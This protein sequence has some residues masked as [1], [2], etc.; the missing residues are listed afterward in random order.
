M[1]SL[2][3]SLDSL[4]NLQ[5]AIRGRSAKAF[6]ATSGKEVTWND[7]FTAE[8]AM[9]DPDTESDHDDDDEDDLSHSVEDVCATMCDTMRDLFGV[10]S[11]MESYLNQCGA[12]ASA[13]L[14]IVSYG[15]EPPAPASPVVSKRASG[16]PA[17]D[18]ELEGAMELSPSK[19]HRGKQAAQLVLRR[20]SKLC[21]MSSCIYSRARPGEPARAEDSLYCVFCDPVRMAAAMESEAGRMNVRVTLSMLKTKDESV[22]RSAKGKVPLDFCASI[23]YC[24]GDSC[25]YNR[26]HP[27]APV[28]MQEAAA[29]GET[30]CIWCSP[31]RMQEAMQ[32]EAGRRNVQISLSIFEQ[33]DTNVFERATAKVPADFVRSVRTCCGSN[34][35]FSLSSPGGTARAR[36]R[37]TL[38]SWCNPRIVRQREA[39]LH[40]LKR[41]TCA[42]R[43]FADYP[44][45][46]AAA[47]S[48]LSEHFKTAPQRAEALLMERA[49]MLQEDVVRICAGN[50]VA[51]PNTQPLSG[52]CTVCENPIPPM[53]THIKKFEC[54]VAYHAA[55][56][57]E[58][59]VPIET[60][61]DWLRLCSSGAYFPTGIPCMPFVQLHWY[62]NACC[63]TCFQTRCNTLCCRHCLGM[64]RPMNCADIAYV[65]DTYCSGA[66]PLCRRREVISP[67]TPWEEGRAMEANDPGPKNPWWDF[68]FYFQPFSTPED[69]FVRRGR[70]D[71]Y[72]GRK[73]NIHR[74]R[75]TRSMF[76]EDVR[77]I[78]L[79]WLSRHGDEIAADP[80][81]AAAL[82][83]GDYPGMPK[84]HPCFGDRAMN[85]IEVH[86]LREERARIS[87]SAGFMG[88]AR[89]AELPVGLANAADYLSSRELSVQRP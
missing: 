38:C 63:R 47:V 5:A 58:R 67:M 55:R 80:D 39:S 28:R 78:E 14:P 36:T 70:L 15:A 71:P 11:E 31:V 18:D 82:C 37:S 56:L 72:P 25:I 22:Y 20:S 81:R 79:I 85:A 86:R 60:D 24:N 40:G 75:E 16:D 69:C 34:C 43:A 88:K 27:G 59:R 17:Q 77:S 64:V 76:S 48:K 65:W 45:V 87:Q 68:P 2:A 3:R 32:T 6:Y 44:D 62:P 42:L 8:P 46:C 52:L 21:Q 83:R 19:R 10:M 89:V 30:Y 66:T 50:L 7:V 41:I 13:P 33:K 29:R 23:R 57:G 12:K 74:E 84:F 54:I 35:V 73:W 53:R 4:S 26:D 1:I 51:N 9:H 61:G 49:A